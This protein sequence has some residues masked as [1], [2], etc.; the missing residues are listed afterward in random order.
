M[1]RVANADAAHGIRIAR[2][3]WRILRNPK[4]KSDID[5][6]LFAK[7][8]LATDVASNI[9]KLGLQS[10]AGTKSGEDRRF[11]KR[12]MKFSMEAN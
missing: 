5:L 11:F 7:I 9:I 2:L 12:G 10:N 8:S 3:S 6:E 1:R 4:R